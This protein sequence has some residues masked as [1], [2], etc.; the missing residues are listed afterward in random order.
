MN[1]KKKLKSLHITEEYCVV[2]PE[3]FFLLVSA[4]II[5]F[6]KRA[7]SVLPA[8]NFL[9]WAFY[10]LHIKYFTLLLNPL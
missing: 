7:M 2:K 9:T 6:H 1:L 3:D 8:I 10:F 4:L 5:I